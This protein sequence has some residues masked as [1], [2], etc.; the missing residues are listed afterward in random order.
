M[1]FKDKIN[2]Y[3]CPVGHQTITIDRDQGTTPFMMGCKHEGCK[4]M[5]Q[6]CMYNNAVQSLTP[7]YEWYKPLDI[8]KVPKHF[9]EH[10]NM[11]GLLIRNIATKIGDET[12]KHIKG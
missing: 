12:P 4:Q 3:T 9:V 2:V 7:E 6:S 11:G 1:S 5:A 8:K 10:V